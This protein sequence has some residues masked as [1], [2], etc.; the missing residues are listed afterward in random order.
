V[1]YKYD[2]L[3]RYYH[4]SLEPVKPILVRATV[5]KLK[6]PRCGYTWLPRKRSPKCCPNC[7]SRLL[8]ECEVEEED[9]V[10]EELRRLR[11]ENAKLREENAKLRERLKELEAEVRERRRRAPAVKRYILGPRTL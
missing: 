8:P 9:Q 2:K 7:S 1:R 10:L 4:Y 6:C 5:A 11:E 3:M